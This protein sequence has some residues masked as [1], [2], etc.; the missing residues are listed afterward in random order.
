MAGCRK[1]YKRKPSRRLSEKR[2][3]GKIRKRIRLGR[4]KIIYI[5]GKYYRRCSKCRAWKPDDTTKSSWCELC[6][7]ENHLRQ[8]QKPKLK[9]KEK[10]CFTCHKI[11]SAKEFSKDNVLSD[12]LSS[13][14]RDCVRVLNKKRYLASKDYYDKKRRVYKNSEKGKSARNRRRRE[15]RKT[16][17][18][19]KLDRRVSNAISQAVK[20]N[21]KS[22]KS[23]LP[24][25]VDQLKRHLGQ[26]MPE[27]YAWQDFLDCNLHIDH[28]IP[29]NEFQYKSH[30]DPEFQ[31]CWALDN[32]RLLSARKNL[33]KGSKFIHTENESPQALQMD[34]V[35]RL[36]S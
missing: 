25:T 33:Q 24:F 20:K 29:R 3:L 30:A 18:K 16:D 1:K 27:G 35:S 22:W 32:L 34:M 21:G 36:P 9:V 12:G 26:T 23:I 7:K 6:R 19:Y 13:N 4:P 8:R 31:A 17:V 15:R 10:K 2:E 5:I 28:I 11:K 14:C